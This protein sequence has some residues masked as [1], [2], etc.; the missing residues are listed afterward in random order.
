MHWN[1][2]TI[3]QLAI[4]LP[5]LCQ[6]TGLLF[7]VSIDAYIDDKQRRILRLI[8]LL[9][10]GL[11]VENYLDM[12]LGAQETLSPYRVLVSIYGY[13]VRPLLLVLS[14]YIFDSDRNYRN[15]W[16][17]TGLNAVVNLTALFSGVCFY[18][19]EDNHYHGGPLS[20]FC[21]VISLIMLTYFV[22]L[23]MQKKQLGGKPAGFIP[24][25]NV[26]LIIVGIF[27]DFSVEFELQPVTFLTI[28]MI[29][30]SLFSYIWLHLQF[31]AEHE[32][33]LMAEQRVQIMMTQIQPH[34]LYNTLSTIQSLCELDPGKAAEV[35]A[36]FGMYLRQNLDSLGQSGL[37]SIQ[38]ELEHTKIYTEIEKVRF[39]YIHVEFDVPDVTFHLPALTIQPLVENAI[40]HGGWDKKD[41]HIRVTV[42]EEAGVHEITIQDDGK[43]FEASQLKNMGGEHIGIRNVKERIEQLCGGTLSV[44]SAVGEGTNVTIRIPEEERASRLDKTGNNAPENGGTKA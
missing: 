29:N 4:L 16:I 17:L 37:I 8:S 20:R 12:I 38:K 31:V 44:N 39:P 3:I 43:G 14:F 7:T 35:T 9:L 26:I 41:G 18:F 25:F 27:L 24:I 40:R 13:S 5:L 6:I 34:F 19:T 33:A 32:D 23:S 30:C 36:N 1:Q 28:A 42:K 22:Y 2:L 15:M 11:I 21:L 10:L